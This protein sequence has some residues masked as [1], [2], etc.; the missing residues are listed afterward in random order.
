MSDVLFTHAYFLRF[1]S[2]Q[3]ETMQPYPPLGT[4][5][6]A[7]YVRQSGY[8]IA[9]FDSMLADGP[10]LFE[11]ALRQHRPTFVVIFEDNFNYLSKMCLTRMRE[12]AFYMIALAKRMGCTVIVSGSD[13]TDHKASYLAQGVDYILVGEGE[14]T[15]RELLDSLSGRSKTAIE[16][17][18]GL[19][20]LHEDT[21]RETD[22]RGFLKQLD[23]LPPPAR[24]LVDISMYETAWRSRHGYFSMNMV[25]T[26]GCPFK[27]NWCAKP[28]YGNRYN[29]H[30]PEY[31]AQDLKRLK[32]TYHP[33]HIW[34]ADDIFG[35][36]PDWVEAFSQNVDALQCKTPFKIQ[37]R[38]DLLDEPVVAALK[39]AGCDMVWVGAE[40]GAQKI[41]DAMDKGT[42]VEQIHEV[43]ERLH[44]HGIKVG[45]FLQFGYP[46]ETKEDID[47]T[48]RMI[49]DCRP[50]DIG[51]SVSYP[52]PGTKFYDRVSQELGEKVNWADSN[53]LALMFQ[54]TFSSDYYRLLHRVVHGKFRTR[55]GLDTLMEL[56]THPIR[57]NRPRLRTMATAVTGAATALVG[58]QR[59]RR[60]EHKNG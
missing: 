30:S 46:G 55:R 9:L 22:R 36:K 6:A 10:A 45:F 53:D 37:A 31:V 38:V 18:A 3:W 32:E 7:S 26:R 5:Y 13:A 47:K 28:I 23:E 39:R 1:D 4:L 2:K 43:A 48:I 49:H 56:A 20:M 35:L 51:I 29:S 54:G 60:M 52:L 34:F 15:L 8:D 19:S 33:D 24:D 42:T 16:D 58:A 44:R 59:L 27:C 40:S 41:L 50:D 21:I 11:E 17:I 14:Y 25:T 57:I 12:A